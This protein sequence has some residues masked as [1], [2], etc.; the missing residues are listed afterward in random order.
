[1]RM[2]HKD[3]IKPQRSLVAH[4]SAV[5]EGKVVRP[6]ELDLPMASPS[7]AHIGSRH[8][9]YYMETITF[10]VEDCIFKVPRCHFEH[11]SEIFGTTF[12]LPTGDG[13]RA[14]GQTDENPVVLQGIRSVDFQALLK[15]LYPLDLQQILTDK[16][17]WMTKE[18]WISVLKLST[19]WYFLDTR[20]LAIDQLNSRADMGGVD[21]ILLARQ[22]DV[23]NWLQ[24]GYADL[25]RRTAGI[26][27]EDAEKIGWETALQLCQVRENALKTNNSS[28]PRNLERYANVE[29][30]F[31]E[32][33]KQAAL[34]SAPYTSTGEPPEM[35]RTPCETYYD[36]ES[37]E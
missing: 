12:T 11:K 27:R 17:R 3:Q 16:D 5:V 34:A 36:E 7:K 23:P 28:Y 1:M 19:K 24:M 9:N 15:V 33:F 35:T 14:E 37:D 26:S 20:N 22:Y 29:G 25:A 32:E 4:D 31:G 13:V 6:T 18:E 2:I 30:A 21:R 10:K 8:Q